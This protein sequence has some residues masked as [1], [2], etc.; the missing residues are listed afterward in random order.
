[1][2]FEGV[3]EYGESAQ[4]ALP[5]AVVAR[6]VSLVSPVEAVDGVGVVEDL[7]ILLDSRHDPL[8]STLLVLLLL[9]GDLNR[10]APACQK[11]ASDFQ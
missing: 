3:S 1:M 2:D 4:T 9:L 11:T 5:T 7:H 10:S 6:D 8:A